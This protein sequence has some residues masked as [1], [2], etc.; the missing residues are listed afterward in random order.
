MAAR[1]AACLP[2][3][4]HASATALYADA[5]KCTGEQPSAELLP[6]LVS[7]V[8]PPRGFGLSCRW[9]ELEATSGLAP[10]ALCGAPNGGQAVLLL[11]LPAAPMPFRSLAERGKY[12]G[13]LI[14]VAR[15]KEAGAKRVTGCS[16][17]WREPR[18]NRH[19][20][21]KKAK[22]PGTGL[23]PRPAQPSTRLVFWP[24][25]LCEAHGPRNR[26]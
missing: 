4:G 23:S 17:P 8:S 15:A 22:E 1:S 18:R 3:T 24:N 5:E 25:H 19:H 16:A 12:L 13:G 14:N 10:L 2:A 11:P 21:K 9:A 6:V 7:L 20:P 26:I